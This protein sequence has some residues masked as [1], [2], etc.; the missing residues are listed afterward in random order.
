MYRRALVSRGLLALPSRRWK[1][2]L[3]A[4]NAAMTRS[5]VSAG[6]GCAGVSGLHS[7]AAMSCGLLGYLAS[8]ASS[9]QGVRIQL[10]RR[11]CCCWRPTATS[12]STYRS[13]RPT[14]TRT[15]FNR[16]RSSA[17]ASKPLMNK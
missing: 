6:N 7:A 14:R 4:L 1:S 2:V 5:F 17:T 10:A 12:S 11:A 15:L 3:N 16:D 13:V 9:H 8:L